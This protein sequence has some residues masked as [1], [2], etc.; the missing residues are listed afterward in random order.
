[1][2]EN[3]VESL[4]I[5]SNENASIKVNIMDFLVNSLEGFEEF[6]NYIKK[7]K[8]DLVDVIIEEAISLS[9]DVEDFG[10]Q[11]D[12]EFTILQKNPVFYNKIINTLLDLLNYPKYKKK[13]LKEE[14]IVDVLDLVKG[15]ILFDYLQA[16]SVLAAMSREEAINL[17]RKYI[18]VTMKSRSNSANFIESL[19]DYV[20]RLK[21][22]AMMWQTHDG[23][24]KLCDDEKL[25]Y[26]VRK[27]KWAEVLQDCDREICYS[28]MCY[29]DLF[30]VKN[31][32]PDFNLTRTK[33]IM[34]GDDY[35]DFCYHDE[36]KVKE[37]IHPSE[38]FWNELN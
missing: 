12:G 21:N 16:S 18:R 1:M 35:C 5:R 37:I 27:C 36:R 4:E 31:L 33:T 28:M 22:T 7:E 26:K 38:K 23:I 14:I 17:I 3:N 2:D 11:V 19:K 20:N 10:V 25:V 15:Y 24:L 34:Q 8:G 32:N 29:Q 9:R 6:L 30:Q 13:P